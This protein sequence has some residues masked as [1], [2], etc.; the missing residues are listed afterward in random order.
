MKLNIYLTNLGKYNEGQLVGKWIDVFNHEDWEDELESI[1][2]K[3]GTEYEEYFITDVESDIDGLR[4]AIGEYTSLSEI[5]VLEEQLECIHE[6]DEDA[7]KAAIELWG[8][9]EALETVGNLEFSY[10]PYIDDEYALGKMAV[11][12]GLMG[13]IPSS[14][15]NY[16]DYDAVGRDWILTGDGGL[17]S[18]GYIERS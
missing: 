12:E 5:V 7:F 1:G 8:L 10:Y 17:T 6:Y 9:D 16:I 4:D 18:M 14:I 13:E 3:H 15:S 2:V 11:D